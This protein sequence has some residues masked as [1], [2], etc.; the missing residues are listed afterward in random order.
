MIFEQTEIESSVAERVGEDL[1]FL[2]KNKF[3]SQT[4]LSQP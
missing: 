1:I 4:N 3:F 2:S